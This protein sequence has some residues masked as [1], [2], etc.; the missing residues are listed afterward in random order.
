MMKNM[1]YGGL[2]PMSV[3]ELQPLAPYGLMLK[4]AMAKTP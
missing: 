4:E 2:T 3:E 1:G